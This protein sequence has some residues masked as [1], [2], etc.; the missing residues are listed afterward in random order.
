MIQLI[1]TAYDTILW[2]YTIKCILCDFFTVIINLVLTRAKPMEFIACFYLALELYWCWVSEGHSKPMHFKMTLAGESFILIQACWQ[3][4]I[5]TMKISSQH[6]PAH[7]NICRIFIGTKQLG[8]YST[9]LARTD[10]TLRL[11]LYEIL[12]LR[13]Y[14][15]LKAM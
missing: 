14:L 3:S 15:I 13:L 4:C 9:K 11:L 7:T 12:I 1:F 2:I 5:P 10:R 8:S 6:S